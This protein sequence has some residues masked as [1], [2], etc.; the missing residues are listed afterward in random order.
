[1]LRTVGRAVVA[2]GDWTRV[3][4]GYDGLSSGRAVAATERT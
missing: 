3:A 1:M 4:D 2:A